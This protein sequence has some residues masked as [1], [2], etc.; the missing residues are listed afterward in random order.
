MAR[1]WATRNNIDRRKWAKVRL[2][3]LARDKNRCTKCGKAGRLEIDHCTPL[4]L[5]GDAYGHGNLRA[6]CRGCHIAVTRQ[7][8]LGRQQAYGSNLVGER[9]A[10]ADLLSKRRKE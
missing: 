1:N 9:K 5:G 3:I 7:Q 4:E 10:W 2:E 6:L 8:N